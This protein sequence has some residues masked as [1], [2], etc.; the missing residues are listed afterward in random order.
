LKIIDKNEPIFANFIT[1]LFLNP[2][3]LLQLEGTATAIA[4]TAMGNLTLDSISFRNVIV[5]NGIYS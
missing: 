3:A 2:T 1:D 4:S 5:A